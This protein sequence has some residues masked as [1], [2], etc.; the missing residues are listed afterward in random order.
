MNYKVTL[1]NEELNH[2]SFN[3]LNDDD[4]LYSDKRC[5]LT[6]DDEVAMDIELT[7]FSQIIINDYNNPVV[8]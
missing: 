8:I 6:I 7:R 1:I 3:V 5:D 4:I 2:V